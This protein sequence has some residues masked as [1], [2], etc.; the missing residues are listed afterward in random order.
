M[1]GMTKYVVTIAPEETP[2]QAT[3]L[4]IDAN[5]AGT[6]VIETNILGGYVAPVDVETILA[7]FPP[8]PSAT[9]VEPEPAPVAEVK[10]ARTRAAKATAKKATKAAPKKTAKAAGGQR[11]FYGPPSDL[12]DVAAKHGGDVKAIA[13]EYGAAVPTVKRWLEK[14]AAKAAPAPAAAKKSARKATTVKVTAD[15]KT[16]F[17]PEVVASEPAAE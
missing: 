8:S 9:P 10:P 13:E 14:E 1:C 11:R 16:P 3:T 5:G 12:A 2:D 4:R 6:R 15:P 17:S 7:A